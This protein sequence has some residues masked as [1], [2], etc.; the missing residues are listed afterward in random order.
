M[1]QAALS[2]PSTQGADSANPLDNLLARIEGA[3]ADAAGARARRQSNK[4]L[5]K[6]LGAWTRGETARAAKFALE[7][8]EADESNAPAFSLLGIAL[9]KLGH[10]HKALVSFERA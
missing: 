7:A 8:T 1:A 9:E 2:M 6:A 10:L 5:R 3:S 4:A